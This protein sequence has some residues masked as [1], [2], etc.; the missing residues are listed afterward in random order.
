MMVDLVQNIESDGFALAHD[1]LTNSQVKNL[2]ALIETAIVVENKHG[3]IR[4]IID[5]VP[6]LREV[7][8]IRDL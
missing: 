4:D 8:R 6:Q 3:G 2:I 1:V 5:S 7:S